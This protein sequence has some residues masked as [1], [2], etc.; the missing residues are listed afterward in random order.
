MNEMTKYFKNELI[1]Q[2]RK[3][4]WMD[5]ITKQRAIEKAQYVEYKSGYPPYIYNETWMRTVW[6]FVSFI[7][8]LA[9]VNF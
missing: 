6:T 3:A 9:S 2:L 1:L 8:L 7:L 4:E 5:R